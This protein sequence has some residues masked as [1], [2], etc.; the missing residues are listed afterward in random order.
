MSSAS[1]LVVDDDALSRAALED[2]LTRA[3]HDPLG[4]GSGAEA[5]DA[6][7]A[8][9]FDAVI[10]DL[11]MPRMDGLELLRQLR[12]RDPEVPVVLVTAYGSVQTAVEAMKEGASDYVTKPFTSQ[13]ILAALNRLVDLRRLQ[14]ENRALREEARA[15]WGFAG[16]VGK[17]APMLAVFDQI[18]TAAGS[19]ATVLVEGESGT[20]K[21]LVARALHV[22]SA[23]ASGPFVPVSCA[24]LSENL[25]ESEIFGH[26]RGAFTGAVA[27]RAGRVEQ[28]DGGT[29]FLDDADDI[30]LG[31]QVKLL[32]ML[33][34]RTVERVGSN[35]A[36]RVDVRVVVATKVDL[37]EEVAQRRFREDLYYR[38][39]VLPIRLPPLRARRGD[40]P[41]LA[42]HFLQRFAARDGRA[43]LR[44]SSG[45]MSC[46]EA[47]SWPGNVRELENVMERLSLTCGEPEVSVE[48]LPAE[49][50][51]AG[52]RAA[53]SPLLCEPPPEGLALI[54]ELNRIERHYIAWALERT[55]GNKSQAARLLQLSRTTLADHMSRLGITS[56]PWQG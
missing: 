12:A 7:R 43:P 16:I 42:A 46:L 36:R 49:Q 38:I 55:R 54:G 4:A 18:R 29:L 40:I 45:A 1:I 51:C 41:L 22:S 5:L 17:S 33:Q 34:E 10:T 53:A 50:R 37:R 13:E 14:S 20:G 19:L 56:E 27:A 44:L 39:C 47:W 24:A 31:A 30:P 11:R 35:R 2:L 3:G 25:L 8:G 26:E 28:A 15:R 9:S 48:A 52:V 32:R 23:R 21:E 6:F